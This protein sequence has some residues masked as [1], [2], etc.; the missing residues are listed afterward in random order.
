MPVVLGVFVSKV[1]ER[2]EY[3][4]LMRFG[5]FDV[6]DTIIHMAKFHGTA[7][8]R[9]QS[10]LLIRYFCPIKM[11]FFFYRATYAL[12][13][14]PNGRYS[15]SSGW[16][17]TKV[18]ARLL[19]PTTVAE[20]MLPRKHYSMDNLGARAR[21]TIATQLG[22]ARQGFSWILFFLSISQ[23]LFLLCPIIFRVSSI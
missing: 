9:F 12:L 6:H 1:P 16:T 3:W 10:I 11:A 2:E 19:D 20:H 8:R 14:G 15:T 4:I 22:R 18:S 13:W 7:S 17:E 23:Q 21:W 5:H